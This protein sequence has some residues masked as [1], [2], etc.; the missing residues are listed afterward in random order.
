MFL[1]FNKKNLILFF[2][3]ETG[4]GGLGVNDPSLKLLISN[5][6]LYLLN[7]QNKSLR[8]LFGDDF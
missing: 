1:L 8:L 7:H 2:C 5:L 3:F 6:L 4:V